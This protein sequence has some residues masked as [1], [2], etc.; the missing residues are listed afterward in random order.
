MP[1]ATVKKKFAT[2]EGEV[3]MISRALFANVHC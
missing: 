3:V 2:R 1:E